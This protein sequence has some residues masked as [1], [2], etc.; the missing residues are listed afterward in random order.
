MR[1]EAIVPPPA[2][3]A[4]SF[5]RPVPP[6]WPLG[7]PFPK[8]A[9]P[10]PSPVTLA[11]S[12]ALIPS[13]RPGPWPRLRTGAAAWC[14][15]AARRVT[16]ASS[17]TPLPPPARTPGRTQVTGPGWGGGARGRRAGARPRRR[18]A[19]P[20]AFGEP[21]RDPAPQ[22]RGSRPQSRC[23]GAAEPFV[24]KGTDFPGRA[25]R[26]ASAVLVGC[27]GPRRPLRGASLPRV[28]TGWGQRVGPA[29]A[30]ARAG[31]ERCLPPPA[32]AQVARW[33]CRDSAPGA[34]GQRGSNGRPTPVGAWQHL[35]APPPPGTGVL[36]E[37]PAGGKGVRRGSP[38]LGTEGTRS[39]PPPPRSAHCLGDK[40]GHKGV[41][42]S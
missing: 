19:P 10:A 13:G 21:P 32:S 3:P 15:G 40:S 9:P 17:P 20:P 24:R 23:W 16:P 36:P 31:S 33:P 38:W 30:S 12:D 6:A 2:A 42:A 22:L 27:G 26:W 18:S 28:L 29:A 1:P 8:D 34:T 7:S 5:Q 37:L 41:C 14:R 25:G 11:A 4:S 35:G 39:T